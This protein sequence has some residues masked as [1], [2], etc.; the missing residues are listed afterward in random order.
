VV[1]DP[2]KV[3]ESG[4]LKDTSNL[5]VPDD[6]G[7][8]STVLL[9]RGTDKLRDISDAWAGY[10]KQQEDAGTVLPL[11]VF[12]VPNSPD[13]REIGKWLDTIFDRWPDLPPDCVANVFGEHKTETF[14][15][16]TVPYIAPERVQESEW[17]R[18]LIAKDAISTG[19]DCPRA[20]VMVSFRAA[21]DRTHI[22]QLLGRMVR[23]PLARRIPGNERLNAV[24]CLLPHFSKKTVEAVVTALMTGADGGEELPGR[25]VLINPREMKPNPCIPEEVWQKLLSL[26]SETLPKRQARPVKRLTALAH[27]LAADGLLPDAGKKAH[28]EMYNVLDGA[29]A[30]YAKEIKEAREAVLSVEGKTVKADLKT[31]AT[32]FN[33]FVE[34][35]DYAVIEDAYR[36]AARVISADLA[37]TYSE[38]LAKKAPK[39]VDAEDS[40][41]EAHIVVASLGLVPDIKVHLEG[42]AEKLSNQW[43]TQ[44]RVAIKSLSDERQEVYRQIREMSAD[45][46]DVDLARPNTWLQST[47]ALEADGKEVK[48]PRFERHLLCDVDRLFPEDF[49]SSWEDKVVLAELERAGSVG[50]YRNPARASQDSLGVTYVIGNETKIAR[51]D[52][53]FF[54]RRQDGSIVADIVDP[55]GIQFADALPRMKGLARY[56][57][58]NSGIYRRIEAVAKLGDKFRTIDLTEASARAAVLN[59]ETVREVYE[60]D[61]VIDYSA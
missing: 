35:A 29:Q 57:E 11:M 23:T 54:V 14:G 47:T 41:I 15:S 49:K 28:A 17:V 5:N 9:R 4:L 60:G 36:R 30:R 32:S 39:D 37:R 61:V 10:A 50:W 16:R 44:F 56:A 19:W 27:E 55:H 40:L 22:T 34:A 18:V 20:E 48:L 26:P 21:S 46:L 12:Q 6:V 58:K 38:H 51:P 3:Q 1:V 2:T 7:D 24:D 31:K 42:E 33:D 53:I 25:R 43:L 52:F 59:A 13:H 45:P 8:F